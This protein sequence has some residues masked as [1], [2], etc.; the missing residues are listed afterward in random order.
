MVAT[1]IAISF[2]ALG[3]RVLETRA[4][5]SSSERQA[6]AEL[7]RQKQQEFL[8]LIAAKESVAEVWAV[9]APSLPDS[10]RFAS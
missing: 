4:Q 1:M 6:R 5:W 10:R 3:K 8:A 2:T 9:G 7:G